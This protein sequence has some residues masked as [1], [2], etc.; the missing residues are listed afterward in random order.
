[1]RE[2]FNM[3]QIAIFKMSSDKPVIFE[4]VLELNYL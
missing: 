3:I 4:P 2:S 1:M